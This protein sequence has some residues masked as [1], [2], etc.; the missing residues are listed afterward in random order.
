MPV[1]RKQRD[2]DQEIR[3]PSTPPGDAGVSGRPRL[4]P[5]QETSLLALARRAIESGLPGGTDDSP[6]LDGASE[7]LR[8]TAATFVP[9]RKHGELR[10]CIGSLE[11]DRPLIESVWANARGA[12]F[13]DPRFSPVE[14][15]ELEAIRIEISLLGP[16]VRLDFDTE[17]D[18]LGQLRPGI[19]GLLIEDGG[20]R[21][22]FLPAVWGSLSDPLQFLSELRSKAGLPADHW[23]P[24]LVAWRYT[25]HSIG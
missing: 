7:A 17:A 3:K 22:T 8:R 24:S 2:R 21:A 14:A 1:E 6:S 13:R 25:T 9:L 10:G 19:D 11:S 23:S 16:L 15:R 12:A 5:E 4:T 20:K 18:L